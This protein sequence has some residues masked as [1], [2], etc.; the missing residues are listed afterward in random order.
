MLRGNGSAGNL[1]VAGLAVLLVAA[2]AAEHPSQPSSQS[3]FS[4]SGTAAPVPNFAHDVAPILGRNCV[5]C[6]R[7]GG[8]APFSLLDYAEAKKHAQQIASATQTRAMP[9]WLPAAGYGDF[10]DEH[11]L[12][13]DEIALIANWVRGGAP[14]GAA[15]EI[16]PPPNFAEGWQLGPPDLIMEAARAYTIPAH[17][18]DVFYNFIFSPGISRAKYVRAI[19]I[20][21]GNTKLIHHANVIVDRARSARRQESEAGAGFAGMNVKIVRNVTDFD[22]HFLFWKPG[23][24]PWVEPDG[25][26]WRLDPG[27]DLVL[28]AHMM[29]MGKPEEV[30]PSIALYFTDKQPKY[31]PIL[32]QL[33]HDG[34][35]NIPP[36][37]A[38][39][40]VTDRFTLP[41]D[42]DALAAYPHAHYLGHILEGYANLPNGTRKQLIWIRHWDPKWQAVYHYREPVFLPKGTV[43]VMRWH[44]D[45]SAANPRNPHRPPQRVLSGN[46]STDEMAHLS[47]QLLPR[48]SGQRSALEEAVMR[49]Q[50]EKYPD[51]YQAHLWLG[52]LKI[53]RMDPS[54]AVTVLREAVRLQ[55]K[56]PEG[57]SWLGVA[58]G[59]IGLSREAIEQFRLALK[60]QPDYIPARYNLAK[61]LTRSGEFTEAVQEFTQVLAT[62][63]QDAQVHNDFGE[64]YL[65]MNKPAVALAQ[66][67]QALAAN[68]SHP[69]A[70]KNRDL[71]RQQLAGR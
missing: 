32:I 15:S 60:F 2:S 10:A 63:P 67:E 6:H 69:A 36:G 52:A 33:E 13:S 41:L 30:K 4:Q 20:R 47:F 48:E 25:F 19:E 7:P 12:S 53:S 9:P 14:E 35:L 34:A 50:L 37:D 51:D 66:F 65:R 24:T 23:S 62:F 45:N 68:P 29:T 43:L 54:G 40:V 42:A 8:V 16:P 28:N 27:N 59:A 31:T 39:F 11:R 3:S 26:A 61:A 56:L 71:A 70:L 18:P 57:H 46:Q 38:D 49:H 44:Y 55:P 58:L 21:T 64:L 17:G 5:S 1:A 22:S